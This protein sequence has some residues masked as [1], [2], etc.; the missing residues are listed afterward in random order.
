MKSEKTKSSTHSLLLYENRIYESA[1]QAPLSSKNVRL[2]DVHSCC[3][4]RP[5]RGVAGTGMRRRSLP[6][7][8]AAGLGRSTRLPSM[9]AVQ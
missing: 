5:Q 8:A 4:S 7:A 2:G 1:E 3:V 6:V 9:L